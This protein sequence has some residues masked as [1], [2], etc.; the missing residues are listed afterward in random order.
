M[1][2]REFVDSDEQESFGK[3]IF[4]FTAL[5]M[6]VFIIFSINMFAVSISLQCNKDRGIFFRFISMMYAF[7]FGFIYLIINLYTYR[8]MTKGE[9]CTWS[10]K[11]VFP[12]F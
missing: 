7:C 3:K 9:T 1:T 12:I 5:Y 10:S 4:K 11:N 6:F 8:F 2:D